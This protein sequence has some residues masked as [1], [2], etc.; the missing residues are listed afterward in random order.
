VSIK[1]F[2]ENLKKYE[3]TDTSTT[4]EKN[5]KVRSERIDSDIL[6]SVNFMYNKE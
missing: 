5:F 6:R 2:I 4:P 3:P 1:I